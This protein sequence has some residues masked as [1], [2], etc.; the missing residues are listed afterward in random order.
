MER[1]IALLTL[2][3]KLHSEISGPFENNIRDKWLL[4]LFFFWD[5]AGSKFLEIIEH[6]E[7]DDSYHIEVKYDSGTRLRGGLD[8]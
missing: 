6:K 1:H 5:V 3:L 7:F 4:H 2:K 8:A